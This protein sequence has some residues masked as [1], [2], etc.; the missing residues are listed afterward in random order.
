M[1]FE[2]LLTSLNDILLRQNVLVPSILV[3]SIFWFPFMVSM[4]GQTFNCDRF[5][6]SLSVTEW[7]Y[8]LV[9]L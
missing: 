7:T 6:A 8:D 5:M 4:N 9:E 3:P 1:F 2:D